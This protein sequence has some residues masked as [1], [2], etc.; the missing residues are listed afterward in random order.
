MLCPVCA[1]SSE[2][3]IIDVVTKTLA[4]HT[5]ANYQIQAPPP[6]AADVHTNVIEDLLRINKTIYASDY[7]L[8]VD[9]SQ[10][11][12]K[13]NDGHCAYVNLCY[14]GAC[15]FFLVVRLQ[16]VD[17]FHQAHT[18]RIFHFHSPI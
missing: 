16:Y 4:F 17:F 13:L 14:D 18:L 6:F 5:S 8:H 3:Q 9:L 15:I 1:D 12:K 10:A 2:L 11:L 7:D